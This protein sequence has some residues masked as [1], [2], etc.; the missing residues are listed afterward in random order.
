MQLRR[1]RTWLGLAAFLAA[2]WL[3]A[4][5]N[6][7]TKHL[8][9]YRDAEPKSLPAGEM[10][11]L[12]T[13]PGLAAAVTSGAGGFPE[14]GCKWDQDQSIHEADTYRLSLD[15]VDDKRVYQGR[16]L[17]V[18]PTYSLEVR[19]GARRVQARLD[20]YGSWGTERT[21]EV[22]EIDLAGGGVY[23]LQPDCTALQNR[24]F[25][26]QVRRL[27]EAYTPQLRTKVTDWNRQHDKTRKLAD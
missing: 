16:C 26:L 22:K 15:R 10:A 1:E 27:P 20:L 6:L 23:F 18:T 17:D 13:D 21:R 7:C 8:Y 24:Q 11:L 9:L 3:L 12:L 2:C 4:G 14:G 19:P 25:V 5:C